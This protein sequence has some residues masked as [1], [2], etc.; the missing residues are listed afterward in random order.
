MR[1]H[2]AL[3]TTLLLCALLSLTNC[4]K[5]NNATDKLDFLK[6]EYFT[7]SVMSVTDGDSFTCQMPDM[8]IKKISL[9]GISIPV[10]REDEAKKFCESILR[11]G[12]LVK[13]EPYDKSGEDTDGIPAYVFVPGGKML[14]VLLLEKGYAVFVKNGVSDKYMNQFAVAAEKADAEKSETREKQ[15]WLR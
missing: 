4:S 9:T 10:E 15:P 7:C 14:N 13:I 8:D 11:R 5:F 12:T 6:Y 3:Q 1:K 2:P